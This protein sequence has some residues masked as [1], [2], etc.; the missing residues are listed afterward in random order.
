MV[1]GSGD[2]IDYLEDFEVM[3][4]EVPLVALGLAGNQGRQVDDAMDGVAILFK[5]DNITLGV[6]IAGPF[7]DEEDVMA[8]RA[9]AENPPAIGML[10][11]IPE[12]EACAL[13]AV[14]AL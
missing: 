6:G 12:A 11:T 3:H 1:A 10:P 5:M 4:L 9:N 14:V 2:L 13:K 8:I 7:I